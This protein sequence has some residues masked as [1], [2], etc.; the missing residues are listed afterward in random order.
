DRPVATG[1]SPWLRAR[2]SS[3]TSAATRTRPW[4]SAA[5]KPEL[6]AARRPQPLRR[7][8]RPSRKA[9]SPAFWSLPPLSSPCSCSSASSS[10]C[11]APGAPSSFGYDTQAAG[12][13][14]PAAHPGKFMKKLRPS[15][16]L[17]LLALLAAAVS[18]ALAREPRQANLLSNPSFE[19]PYN[20]DGSASGWVRWHRDTQTTPENCSDAYASLPQW[21]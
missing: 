21:R 13:G 12:A 7:Q 5:A 1:R 3:L 15:L 2:P 6:T 14:A 10:S 8:T 20:A 17:L 16:C 11:S 19:D 18:Q 4:S 9:A